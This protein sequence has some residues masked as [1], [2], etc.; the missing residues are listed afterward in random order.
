MRRERILQQQR[1]EEEGGEGWSG[2]RKPMARRM[3]MRTAGGEAHLAMAGRMRQSHQFQK[4][5][6][7]RLQMQLKERRGCRLESVKGLGRRRRERKG[8]AASPQVKKKGGPGRGEQ[9]A[10]QVRE[11]LKPLPRAPRRRRARKSQVAPHLNLQ[12]QIRKKG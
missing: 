9:A 10:L 2:W 4:G 11:S 7:S 12:I 3:R 1:Q 8:G 5:Q 6:R